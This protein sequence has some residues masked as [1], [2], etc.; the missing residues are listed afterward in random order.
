MTPKEALAIYG[1]V[2][3]PIRYYRYVSAT[4]KNNKVKEYYY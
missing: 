2:V 3:T 1:A 4:V